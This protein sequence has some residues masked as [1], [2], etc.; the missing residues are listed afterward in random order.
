MRV[1]FGK[2]TPFH[3]KITSWC[4]GKD[5]KKM[6]SEYLSVD[7]AEL[8]ITPFWIKTIPEKSEKVSV[9]VKTLIFLK[10]SKIYRYPQLCL[11]TYF[12]FLLL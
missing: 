6:T 10:N 7:V 4:T 12:Y 1:S 11:L 3:S 8:T 5:F 2:L 9:V